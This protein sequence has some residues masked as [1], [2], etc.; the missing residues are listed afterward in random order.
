MWNHVDF[1][2]LWA[3]LN[4]LYTLCGLKILG[5]IIDAFGELRDQQEQVKED[6]EVKGHTHT[7]PVAQ[8][9]IQHILLQHPVAHLQISC[10]IPMWIF[11]SSYICMTPRCRLQWNT[12]QTNVLCNWTRV[13]LPDQMLYLWNRQRLLWHSA[14]WLWNAHATGAQL[15]QLPVSMFVH[16]SMCGLVPQT[17]SNHSVL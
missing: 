12:Q 15:S 1:K 13:S 3:R 9:I 11:T 5:L 16:V 10:H 4:N 7:H 6:M 8:C 14:T 2:R 17:Y